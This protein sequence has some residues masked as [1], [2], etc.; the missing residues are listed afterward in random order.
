M[1]VFRLTRARYARDLSGR[2]A[3]LAG[4]RWNSKGTALLYTSCSRSL[5]LLELAVHLPLN[6]VPIDYRLVSIEIPDD[7]VEQLDKRRLNAQWKAIPFTTA[8]ML[9]GDQFVR[10]N[11]NL[12]LQVP[13]A[14]VPDEFNV[15]INPVHAETGRIKVI[16]ELPFDFDERLFL[17]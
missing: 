7:S 12:A 16:E 1:I 11:R 15:L 2:A 13:S 14:I 4:G 5:C 10:S 8:T 6:G 9:V 3:E 17:R